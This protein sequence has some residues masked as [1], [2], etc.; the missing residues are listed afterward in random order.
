[1]GAALGAGTVIVRRH[2]M[3]E[4]SM[5]FFDSPHWGNASLAAKSTCTI[6][7]SEC[8]GTPNETGDLSPSLSLS[9]H[10]RFLLLL[11]R[12]PQSSLALPCRSSL[13]PHVGCVPGATP[14]LGELTLTVIPAINRRN[15]TYAIML[16]AILNSRLLAVGLGPCGGSGPLNSVSASH[17]NRLRL[18]S[19]DL[20]KGEPMS[21]R[22][23]KGAHHQHR[24][25]V[26]R[27]SKL[28]PHRIRIR[29]YNKNSTAGLQYF[30]E[31]CL[32]Q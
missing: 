7:S 18:L 22:F 21:T 26:H 30:D 25:H 10:L 17:L 31:A 23:S 11:C 28:A 20:P 32:T 16:G 13:L 12:E 27:E 4:S 8:A 14:A 29:G 2:R 3:A 1:M 15:Y 9:S 19:S 5:C 24:R 6:Y